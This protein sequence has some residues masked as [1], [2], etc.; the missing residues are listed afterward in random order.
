MA[1]KLKAFDVTAR[2]VLMVQTTIKAESL[3]DAVED[4]KSL[5]EV[6]FVTILP[7]EFMDGSIRITGVNKGGAWQTEQED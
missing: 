5:R 7:N 6:D 2:L 4:A 1:T 3:A